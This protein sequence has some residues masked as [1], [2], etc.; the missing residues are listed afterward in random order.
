MQEYLYKYLFLNRK[1]SI[2]Q[3]GSFFVVKEP[4]Y[5]NEAAGLLF[6]PRPVIN[7]YAE[8]T[9]SLPEKGFFD[10]LAEE[11]KVD[12]VTALKEF[13][14]FSDKIRNDLQNNKMA[15]L[16]GLGRITKGTDDAC[17]F[18]A[19]TNLLAIL[20]PIEP[21][22]SIRVTQ[23]PTTNQPLKAR[24]TGVIKEM[25]VAEV[26]ETRGKDNWWIYAIILVAAGTVALVY[27]YQ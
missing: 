15:L 4:A 6:A 5:I 18:T 7:F 13:N 22:I 23:K 10:F 25:L 19:E 14:A 26:V 20:P 2:P 24:E 3:L 27:Y 17:F 11:M 1:L 21:G 9:T 8:G 12:E 16:P